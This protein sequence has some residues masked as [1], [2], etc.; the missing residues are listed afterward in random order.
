MVSDTDDSKV[1]PAVGRDQFRR[2][3]LSRGEHHLELIRLARNMMICH[4]VTVAG[5]DHAASEA[6]LGVLPLL[7]RPE[8]V[9]PHGLIPKPGTVAVTVVREL[10]VT[11][12]GPTVSA[13]SAK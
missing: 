13:M 8:A 7:G 9:E 11:T 2:V 6:P 10:M 12:L 1:G 4:D 5:H 3:R